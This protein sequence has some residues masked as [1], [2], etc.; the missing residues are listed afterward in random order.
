M[1]VNC[2]T[3]TGAS[4]DVA[5]EQSTSV[6]RRRRRLFGF[7]KGRREGRRVSIVSPR[8]S[9]IESQQTLSSSPTHFFSTG[10]RRPLA[11]RGGQ[12]R[13]HGGHADRHPPGKGKKKREEGKERGQFQKK[14]ARPPARWGFVCRH[15]QP[16]RPLFLHT[17]PK[18]ILKDEDTL[19]GVGFGDASFLVLMTKVRISFFS[20]LLPLRSLPLASSCCCPLFPV[21]ISFNSSPSLSPIKKNSPPPRRR[22][23][24]SR[25]QKK[26]QRE[27]E[28]ER[29]ASPP[30]LPRLPSPLPRLPS[31]LPPPLL[32][33]PLRWRLLPQQKQERQRLPQQPPEATPT[34]TRRRS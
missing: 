10:I 28:Q 30:P 20:L 13:A 5:A 24:P 29:A 8:S 18:Q 11:H 7:G 9:S 26:Q 15:S 31:P 22:R 19:G 32:P 3:V 2:K 1:K 12:A 6:R 23:S 21:L 14:T 33:L 27:Q 4:F 34:P 25:R 17:T 16:R